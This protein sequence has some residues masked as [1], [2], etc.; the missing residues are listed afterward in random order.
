MLNLGLVGKHIQKSQAPNLLTRLSKEFNFPISYK[1]FDLQNI[2]EVNFELFINELKEKK[3]KG[4]NV[5]FPFKEIAAKISHKKGEE[6]E[7]T[8]SSNLLLL[9]EKIISRNTDYL[10]FEKLLNYHFK[11]KFENVLVLGGGG[12][13]RS[14]CF[15]LAKFGLNK[16]FLLEKD[17]KKSTQLIDELKKIGVDA[18]AISLEQLDKQL[19]FDGILNCTEVGHEHSPGNIL[20]NKDLK[21]TKWIFDAVYIPAE[22][23]LI[24]QAKQ[25]GLK[26]ISGIDLF[27]F[28]GVEGFII[29]SD[30]ENLRQNLYKNI[31]KIREFYFNK[32]T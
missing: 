13:G 16:L 23:E 15:A 5:T 17:I 4:I 28:Q 1:L 21:K 9:D 14:I 31:E 10:G 20:R 25:A 2:E 11:E 18:V 22:T 26:I 32:L 7:I 8:K 3:I 6:V 29:F 30:H 24:K 19:I 27:I 12:I